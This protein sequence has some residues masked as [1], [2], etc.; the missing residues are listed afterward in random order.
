MGL[1]LKQFDG[2]VEERFIC[3][4]CEKVFLNPL[5]NKC[6][7][8]FCTTC[9]GKR[10][11][12]EINR[13]CPTCKEPLV[14]PLKPPTKEFRLELLG[15]PIQCS[16][17]CGQVLP[18][19]GLPD[20]VSDSC[21]F[22]GVVC[23]NRRKGC[24]RKIRRCDVRQHVLECDYREV[25]CEACGHVT[26][27]NDIFT[28][29]SRTKCLEKKLKQQVIRESKNHQREVRRHQTQLNKM[30]IRRDIED[31]KILVHHAKFLRDSKFTHNGKEFNPSPRLTAPSAN[32]QNGDDV[33][34]TEVNG[35]HDDDIE[36]N[37]SPAPHPSRAGHAIFECMRCKKMFSS[38]TNNYKSCR[39]HA[40]VSI[41][42]VLFQYR[43]M[44]FEFLE[45]MSVWVLE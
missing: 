24:K 28:H 31:R 14:T 38:Q 7:H 3:K 45:D 43:L 27:Y 19:E 39:W 30:H 41:Y 12:N 36:S 8:T 34:M 16:N 6:G 18:L 35:D 1:D 4:V 23:P 40:G 32:T 44:I 10:L 20:H 15:L 42:L 29:Q 17:K 37:S 21:P 22:T 33:F 2:T 13:F 9:I 26:M 25:K 11:S 5:L